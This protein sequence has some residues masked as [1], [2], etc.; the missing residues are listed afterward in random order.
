MKEDINFDFNVP[1][2]VT[3]ALDTIPELAKM[4]NTD[5]RNLYLLYI[6]FECHAEISDKL[7]PS[8]VDQI[9]KELDKLN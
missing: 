8:Y 6:I 4:Q 9:R 3:V 5:L 1:A 7:Q 2:V